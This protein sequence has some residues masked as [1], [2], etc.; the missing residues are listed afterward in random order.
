[1]GPE[2]FTAVGT[3]KHLRQDFIKETSLQY[4]D[5]MTKAEALTA[6]AANFVHL[7][8]IQINKYMQEL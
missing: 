2:L 8:Y 3:G 5:M 7:M 1:M 6:A 4:C